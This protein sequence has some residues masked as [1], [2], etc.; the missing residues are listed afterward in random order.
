[1]GEGAC[2]EDEAAKRRLRMVLLWTILWGWGWVVG[3][4]LKKQREMCALIR[5]RGKRACTLMLVAR[6]KGTHY[7]SREGRRVERACPLAAPSFWQ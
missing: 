3:C 2:V 4:E 1:M 7:Y 5:M 6:R